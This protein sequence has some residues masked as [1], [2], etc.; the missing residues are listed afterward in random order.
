VRTLGVISGRAYH[1]EDDG[2]ENAKG[3]LSRHG[4]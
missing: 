1:N 4:H 3:W 2:V